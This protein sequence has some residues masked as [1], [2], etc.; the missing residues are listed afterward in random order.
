[1]KNN[2]EKNNI[3]KKNIK[4]FNKEEGGFK[5]ND[6]WVISKLSLSNK[7]QIKNIFSKANLYAR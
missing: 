6:N 1:M 2:I 4:N 5:N 7:F 3:V